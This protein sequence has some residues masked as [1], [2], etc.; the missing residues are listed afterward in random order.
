[1]YVGHFAGGVL[2]KALCPNTPSLPIIFGVGWLDII[3]G[4]LVMLGIDHVRPN[5]A[6]GPYLFFDLVFVDWDHSLLM[7]VIFSAVWAVMMKS[8]YG[9]SAPEGLALISALA[10]FSHWLGDVPFHNLDLAAYPYSEKH[11]GWG[12]W[13]RFLTMSWVYEGVFSAVCLGL[14]AFIFSR[15]SVDIKWTLLVH[16]ALFLNLSPWLSPMKF[17]ATLG[18]PTD[19]L[20]HGALVTVGFVAPGYI[21][22]RLLDKSEEEGLKR[23]LAKTQ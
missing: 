3:D 17:V 1:M 9:T 19:Y 22:C 11:F 13:G 20:V 4:V 21:L 14:A 10:V 5:P 18:H 15:R 12:W 7:A 6:A 8:K 16:G 23:T 2:I